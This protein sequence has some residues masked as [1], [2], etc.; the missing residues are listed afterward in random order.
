MMSELHVHDVT[1]VYM[2]VQ[3]LLYQLL[4]LKPGQLGYP[5]Y[6]IKPLLG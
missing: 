2:V 6:Q 3:G 5:R 1:D 4:G